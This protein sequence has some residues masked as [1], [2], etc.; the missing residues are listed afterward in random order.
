MTKDLDEDGVKNADA[1]FVSD[2]EL[3]EEFTLTDSALALAKPDAVIL[4]TL[5]LN[6]NGNVSEEVVSSP[7]FCALD[8]AKNLP[9]IEMA[10]LSLLVNK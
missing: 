4:H 8:E 7:N 1:I 3:P 9:L 6:E 2:D 5:P 10:V